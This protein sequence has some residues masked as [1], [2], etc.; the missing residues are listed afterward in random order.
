SPNLPEPSFTVAMSMITVAGAG[1]S[2]SVLI[3]YLVEQTRQNGWLLRVVDQSRDLAVAKAGDAPHVSVAEVRATNEKSLEEALIGSTVVISMLPPPFHPVVAQVCLKVGA[4]LLTASYETDEMRALHKDVRQAGLF[5]LNEC[6]LDP[7]IDHMSALSMMDDVRGQGGRIVSFQSYCGGLVADDD[8]PWGYKFTWNPRNVVLAGREGARYLRHG[9]TH[10][11]PYINLFKRT[12]P[13]TIDGVGDFEGYANRD[14][15]RYR[16]VYNLP[17]ID[18]LLRGTLRRPGFC[19]AWNALVRLGLTDL[20]IQLTAGDAR[21]WE[22][23]IDCFLPPYDSQRKSR[24]EHFADYLDLDA[25]GEVMQ[26]LNWLGIFSGH[27]VDTTAATAPDTLQSLLEER[28]RLLPAERDLIV[29]QHKLTWEGDGRRFVRT[30][31][32]AVE[33]ADQTRTAMAKTVGL[34]LGIVAM[35]LLKGE[36]EMRGVHL[37]TSP[38]LYEPVLKALASH[39][40]SFRETE[41]AATAS[42]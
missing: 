16:D 25:E 4:H 29:M 19:R 23:L 33:G 39:G 15:V 28:W 11:I 18:T 9:R 34:P 32:L 1:R 30:S 5:F 27:P 26:R 38:S 20:N 40:I 7:G 10:Y 17:H 21:T 3:E 14:S 12:E 36:I 42:A 22:A 8:T 35:M 37:P 24:K 31:S 13:I 41:H 6:G 2:S